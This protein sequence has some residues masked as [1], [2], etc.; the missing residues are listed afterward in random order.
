MDRVRYEPSELTPVRSVVPGSTD[1]G[2]PRSVSGVAGAGDGSGVL[3]VHLG[4]DAALATGR[5]SALWDVGAD[6][7]D[8][9]GHQGLGREPGSGDRCD[10]EGQRTGGRSRRDTGHHDP[11]GTTA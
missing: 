10:R 5:R 3:S 4:S 9:P 1:S 2:R 6:L 11:I 7:A 8:E